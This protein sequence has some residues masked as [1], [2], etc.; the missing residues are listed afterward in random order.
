MSTLTVVAHI[1]AQPEAAAL[2]EAE[3]GKLVTCTR[4]EE[5]CLQYDLH[6]DTG[7]PN[8]FTFYERWAS[9][10]LWQKHLQTPHV[11]AYRRATEGA[12]AEVSLRELTRLSPGP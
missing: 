5:G 9:R 10:E 6:R 12:V 3:L 1:T 2:V 8:I 7:Q 4:Q 11:A